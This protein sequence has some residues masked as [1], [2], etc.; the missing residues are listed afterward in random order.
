MTSI[1]FVGL[2][3]HADTIA[4][5]VAELGGEVR[6]LGVIP[7][8]AE[9]VRKLVKKL[10]PAKRLRV[11]YEA[12]CCGYV[13]HRQLQELGASCT[14]VAPSLVPTAP[15][16]RVKTDRRDAQKLA[17]CFR[18]GDLT[19]VWVPDRA[20]EALRDLVRQRQAAKSDQ[21]R[22]RNRLFQ[23]L[24]RNGLA[25]P[26]KMYSWGAHHM[27]WLRTL[28]FEHA[29]HEMTMADLLA[30]VEHATDRLARLD[31]A[32]ETALETAPEAT[33]AV[34]AGL[35]C[36]RGVRT[37]TAMTLAVE[38]GSFSR[39]TRATELM[40]YSGAVPSEH[41][42]GARIRHGSISKA[43]NARLR[44][45]ALEAAWAYRFRPQ[46]SEA[47]R[48]RQRG[49][50]TAVIEIAWKA[51]SRL[52]D[53]YYSLLARGKTKQTTITAVAREFL[54]FAWSIAAHVERQIATARAAA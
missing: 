19:A 39:F 16:D 47:L 37:L 24:L 25:P 42:S 5:A 17:R 26:R 52:H 51:Q 35:R 2:D 30:E 38:V 53:K 3:V 45:I 10:G 6:S 18:A 15:G 32:I 33:K 14:I 9:A 11:C 46:L 27:R 41:S 22:A 23:F 1:R 48:T 8:R 34:V 31:S 50:P 7:N 29:A 43:G 4:V 40:A 28:R 36:M 20:H 49:Q 44:R 12:G 13:L 54:G 21:A